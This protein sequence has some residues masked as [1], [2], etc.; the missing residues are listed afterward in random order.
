CFH[1]HDLT[2][3]PF[4]RV[5]DQDLTSSVNFTALIEYGRDYGLKLVS[6]ERQTAFLIRN[7]LIERV[8][9]EYR[10]DEIPD[11]L[12]RRLAVKNFFVPGGLS[13]SF[14][15]LIQRREGPTSRSV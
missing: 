6:F 7:G 14:R 2:D 11:S 13:D 12:S 10:S 1:R 15:V 5:G 8:A 3:N 4:E 9:A